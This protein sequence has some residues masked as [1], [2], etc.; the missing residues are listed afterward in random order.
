M[1]QTILFFH[2]SISS[3]ANLIFFI[4][5]VS[6][7][8]KKTKMI[9]H[10]I[11]GTGPAYKYGLQSFGLRAFL[12][13]PVTRFYK[14]VKLVSPILQYYHAVISWEDMSELPQLCWIKH[15]ITGCLLLTKRVSPMPLLVPTFGTWGPRGTFKWLN[16]VSVAQGQGEGWLLPTPLR[17]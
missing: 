15:I 1:Q 7:P 13:H 16:V 2:F 3:S 11:S 10:P 9:S 12:Q 14:E 4:F 8:T 6:S 5:G 17:S